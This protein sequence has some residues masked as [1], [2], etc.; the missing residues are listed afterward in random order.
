MWW[1]TVRL[2]TRPVWDQKIC[3]GL[4]DLVLCCGTRSCHAR[5]HNDLEGHNN[6]SSTI[7]SFS[8]KCLEINSGVYLKVNSAKCLCL[9]PVV[10][11]LVLRIWSFVYITVT[12]IWPAVCT[13][14]FRWW[15]APYAS[16]KQSGC[17][18]VLLVGPGSGGLQFELVEAGGLRLPLRS[19]FLLGS[20]S[21]GAQAKTD[22]LASAFK[23]WRFMNPI[24]L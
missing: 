10:L 11:V 23:T 15:Y 4:A 9:L 8:V 16:C 19:C 20:F 1:E 5:R 21:P 22:G 7:Y 24:V 3:L 12:D 2:M 14:T 13:K 17:S 18:D 6:F